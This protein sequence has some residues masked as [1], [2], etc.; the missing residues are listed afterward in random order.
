MVTLAVAP[1]CALPFYPLAL[2][3]THFS[4]GNSASTKWSANAPAGY[5]SFKHGSEKSELV[6][7]G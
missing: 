3:T 4:F 2:G 5:Q 7:F 1:S 6:H